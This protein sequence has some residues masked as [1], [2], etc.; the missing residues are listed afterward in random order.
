[1]STTPLTTPIPTS[2]TPS[3]A[4]DTLVAKIPTSSPTPQKSVSSPNT[5]AFD[6]LVNNMST[7]TNSSLL[8]KTAPAGTAFDN[9]VSGD[10]QVTSSANSIQQPK[11]PDP[12]STYNQNGNL[13]GDNPNVLPISMRANAIA[14]ANTQYNQQ[15]KEDNSVGGMVKNFF[16]SAGTQLSD[17]SLS[18]VKQVG[19]ILGG[20]ESG[21]DL[22][23]NGA[24]KLA[25][26]VTGQPYIANSPQ[27]TDFSD[28]LYN[29]LETTL[30]VDTNSFN[31][32]IMSNVGAALPWLAGGEL[33]KGA[34]EAGKLA[35]LVANLGFSAV[36]GMMVASEDYKSSKE[37]GESDTTAALKSVGVF[38]ATMAINAI[39]HG[40]SHILGEGV[41]QD[42]PS[43]TKG[44]I[45][46]LK[47][48]L[49][50]TANM[51][52]AQTVISN[53]SQGR[54]IFANVGKNF[55][56]AAPA[57]FAFSAL[58][59]AGNQDAK[60][61]AEK[62]TAAY[63][64]VIA[65]GG[66]SKETAVL[67]YQQMTGEKN[68]PTKTSA[69]FNKIIARNSDLQT[70]FEQNE[71]NINEKSETNHA[72]I[73]NSIKQNGV[74]VTHQAAQDVHNV[75]PKDAADM[76][77][78]SQ[79][80]ASFESII[81]KPQYDTNLPILKAFENSK[82]VE[83]I[84]NFELGTYGKNSGARKMSEGQTDRFSI[85]ELPETIK[86]ITESYR[87]SSNPKNYRYDNIAHVS[88]MPNGE[89]RIIYTRE[90]ARG[91][92]EI[93]NWHSI[94]S[95]KAND[96]IDQLKSF[97]APDQS[98]T[99]INSL[100]RNRPNPLADRG[101]QS[102]SNP[103]KDVNSPHII[104]S[105]SGTHSIIEQ[106]G[107]TEVVS[108]EK[109][110]SPVEK[111]S[112]EQK[113]NLGMGNKP[114][115]AASDT[116]KLLVSKGLAEIPKEDM[117]QYGSGVV[118]EQTEKIASLLS[119]RENFNAIATGEKPLPDGIKGTMLWNVAMRTA[120]D[121]NNGELMARLGASPLASESSEAGS[122]LRFSQEGR[123]DKGTGMRAV[124]DAIKDLNK[125]KEEESEKKQKKKGS[126]VKKEL[127]KQKVK[128]DIIKKQGKAKTISRPKLKAFIDSLPDC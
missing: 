34:T 77:T 29:K 108:H 17:L 61:Q 88:E 62:Q 81:K 119:D 66:L 101:N 118:K 26:K 91:K 117:A 42:T 52:A 74:L 112:A 50:E 9:L 44:L 27:I 39:T 13:N 65:D 28:S 86:N 31:H 59:E 58:G 83:E 57:M 126:S 122:A 87:A 106:N 3:S 105:E 116:N 45:N 73:Q 102:I 109:G 72:D 25:D 128:D 2:P 56:E 113:E 41:A 121:E 111:L 71:T 53:V 8:A 94:S 49:I 10:K 22:I 15:S 93:L 20:L 16:S 97:G 37:A 64:K 55:L 100:E 90:N 120:Y 79:G 70:K 110:E 23:L 78:Q 98:R 1:M 68:D 127:E 60:A 96:Y 67:K 24:D 80:K 85:S 75:G 40:V 19:D 123:G 32:A 92:E 54:P 18:A 33:V 76:I 82:P 36:Q 6:T 5:S 48:G 84:G 21:G 89:K 7:K 124:T 99:G 104:T 46:W 63:L 115:K 114:S 95:E 35:P 47:A 30:G 125:T 38:A 12:L 4:F 51:G 103:E 43:L 69:Y 11:T 107:K 14:S